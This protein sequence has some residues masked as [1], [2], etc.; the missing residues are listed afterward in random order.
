MSAE[1]FATPEDMERFLEASAQRN[2]GISADEFRRRL[3]AG[4]Y[5]GP[6]EN[7]RAMRVRMLMPMTRQAPTTLTTGTPGREADWSKA[8]VALD[9]DEPPITPIS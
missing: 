3:A 1:N 2:L 5:D 7:V 4:E 6:P 9:D 8:T